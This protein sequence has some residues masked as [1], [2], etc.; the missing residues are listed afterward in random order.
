M[1]EPP[2]TFLVAAVGPGLGTAL[3]CLLASAGNRVVAVARSTAATGPIVAHARARGWDV[4]ARHAD[5]LDGAQA[6]RLITTTFEEFGRVD[7]ISINVGA[8]IPGE[9]L[10]HRLSE[11]EW[12]AAI[13]RNLD[14]VYR[15]GRAALPRLIAQGGGSL[16]LVSASLAV[17]RAGNTAYDAAKAG[18]IEL[19][20][21]LARD[22]RAFGIR[23]N[24]VLPGSMGHD[25]GSF[26]PPP[27]DRPIPL[28]N[29]TRTSAWEVA[30]AIRYLLTDESRWV[31]GT[32]LTVDG[33]ESTGGAEPATAP[34]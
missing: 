32:T 20:A 15:I 5:V 26:D 34:R 7:G 10:L 3:V 14:G 22:Y 24:G 25:L 30:R 6:E 27:A 8:W 2:K 19:V 12:A 9:T 17:R 28:T 33:G 11:E 29:E 4:V 13:R 16:A 18:V 23:V 21:R 31:S 1:P